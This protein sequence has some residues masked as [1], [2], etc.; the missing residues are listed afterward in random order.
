M[1]VATTLLECDVKSLLDNQGLLDQIAATSA[2]MKGL[3]AADGVPWAEPVQEAVLMFVN[4]IPDLAK[5]QAAAQSIR[6]NAI[7]AETVARFNAFM[8]MPQSASLS[9]PFAS[10]YIFYRAFLFPSERQP[11]EKKGEEAK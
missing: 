1:Y 4:E 7:T 9:N 8:A 2:A 11:D 10:T 5:K 3:P 6:Q